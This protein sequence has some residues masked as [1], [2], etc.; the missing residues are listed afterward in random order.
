MLQNED[1]AHDFA[2]EEWI[3]DFYD[4]FRPELREIREE[5]DSIHYISDVWCD[6]R[7]RDD[8]YVRSC[9]ATENSWS[10][11]LSRWYVVVGEAPA[12][13]SPLVEFIRASYPGRKVSWLVERALSD[14]QGDIRSALAWRED[15]F[16]QPRPERAWY[17][18]LEDA[19]YVSSVCHEGYSHDGSEDYYSI[20][21]DRV[22]LALT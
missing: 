11:S 4:V 15:E 12:E 8:G 6:A 7:G 1:K 22:E 20:C 3:N 21:T 16:S 19:C 14:V 17:A 9:F 2:E 18:P 5:G 13:D 10:T